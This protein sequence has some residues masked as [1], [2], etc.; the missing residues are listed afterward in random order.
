M[1]ETPAAYFR[2]LYGYGYGAAEA[3]LYTADYL[4]K[5]RIVLFPP[6]LLASRRLFFHFWFRYRQNLSGTTGWLAGLRRGHRPPPGWKRVDG[7]LLSPEAQKHL[8]QGTGLH[9]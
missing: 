7:I 6:Y 1:R 4:R 2:M 5:L 8:P 9:P 3:Q